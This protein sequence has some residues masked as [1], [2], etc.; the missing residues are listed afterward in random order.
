M[1]YRTVSEIACSLPPVSLIRPVQPRAGGRGGRR[2]A[3]TGRSHLTHGMD[4]LE[5]GP[6]GGRKEGREEECAARRRRLAELALRRRRRRRRRL[7]RAVGG[8]NRAFL[9]P[10]CILAGAAAGHVRYGSA[11]ALLFYGSWA[12]GLGAR[13]RCK[14]FGLSFGLRI[15][16][17]FGLRFPILEKVQNWVV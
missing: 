5:R 8:W 10:H 6:A 9:P 14:N 4:R 17:T 12:A 2:R 15:G 11:S 7:Q 16:L 1:W 3:R 13:F